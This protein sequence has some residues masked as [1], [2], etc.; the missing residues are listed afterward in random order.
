M[1]AD[2]I[3]ATAKIG[4]RAKVGTKIRELGKNVATDGHGWTKMNTTVGGR[5]SSKREV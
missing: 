2:A 1:A 3:T 5:R 4:E